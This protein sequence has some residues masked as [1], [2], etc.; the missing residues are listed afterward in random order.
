MKRMRFII[1][2]I[3]MLM[4]TTMAMAQNAGDKIIGTYK[5]VQEGKV[6]KVKISKNGNGYRAQIIWLAE[7]NNPD[8]TPKLDVRN[9]EKTKRGVRADHIVIIDKVTYK[10]GKWTNGKVYDP[11]KGKTFDVSIKF[12]DDKTLAVTGSL[13]VFS[14]TVYWTKISQ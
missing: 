10:D 9:P 12:K 13:L 11:T 4:C 7:P 8:G 5:A 3:A 1:W 2:T 14:K 6:S